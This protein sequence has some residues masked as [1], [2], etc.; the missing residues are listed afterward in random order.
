MVNEAESAHFAAD[1][2]EPPRRYLIFVTE[3]RKSSE[4]LLGRIL[5]L[6]KDS[7]ESLLVTPVP[8]EEQPG[9]LIHS[10]DSGYLVAVEFDLGA[11]HISHPYLFG[12]NRPFPGRSGRLVMLKFF[13]PAGRPFRE[14]HLLPKTLR[15]RGCPAQHGA[16]KDDPASAGGVIYPPEGFQGCFFRRANPLSIDRPPDRVPFGHFFDGENPNRP[17]SGRLFS[18]QPALWQSPKPSA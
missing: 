9:K 6:D 7:Q 16:L 14:N 4:K 12:R 11:W 10:L 3:G 5:E 15:F 1:R 17:F 13:H 18:S 8:R 2:L